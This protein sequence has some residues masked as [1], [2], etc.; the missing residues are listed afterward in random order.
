MVY[1]LN[2]FFPVIGNMDYLI[3][4]IG[5]DLFANTILYHIQFIKR[6]MINIFNFSVIAGNT[7]KEIEAD[8]GKPVITNKNAI[9]FSRLISDVIEGS[10]K[11][12]KEK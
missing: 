3:I 12:D 7:R 6:P 4:Q 2:F 9:D 8:T 1:I 10:D 11:N 5:K